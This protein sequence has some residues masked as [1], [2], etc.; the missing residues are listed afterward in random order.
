MKSFIGKWMADFLCVVTD[1]MMNSL[2]KVQGKKK[3][4]A[5]AAEALKKKLAIEAEPVKPVLISEQDD[6]PTANL[7]A[8]KDED[9]IF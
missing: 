2:K 5:E 4:D 1:V 7:L 6:E 9:V 3:R 8:T